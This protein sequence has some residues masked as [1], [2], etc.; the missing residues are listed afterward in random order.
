MK[1]KQVLFSIIFALLL[2]NFADAQTGAGKI[3]GSILDE[4]QKP[5]DGA[6]V[7]LLIAKDSTVVSTQLAGKDG[8]FGFQDLKDNTYLV[9]ATYIGYK[10]FRSGNVVVA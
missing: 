8:S 3:S 9:K 10:N 2:F 5:L 4:A 7:V 1:L 6:T